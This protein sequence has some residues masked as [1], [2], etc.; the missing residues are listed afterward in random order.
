MCRQITM[1]CKILAFSL[2]KSKNI[3]NKRKYAIVLSSI[4]A[5]NSVH[6]KCKSA[7]RQ[8]GK[9]AGKSCCYE[10]VIEMAPGQLLHEA[11]WAVH[12]FASHLYRTCTLIALAAVHWHTVK[13]DW[14]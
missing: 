12:Q 14:A 8:A 11:C 2:F 5:V 9:R 13:V 10:N 7:G 3:T 6:D 4:F 1:K